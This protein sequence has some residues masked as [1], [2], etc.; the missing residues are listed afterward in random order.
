[1]GTISLSANVKLQNV[2]FVHDFKCKLIF[3]HKLTSVLSC[4][5]TYH[6]N[7]CVMQDQITMRMTESSDLWDGVYVFKMAMEGSSLATIRRYLVVI[8]VTSPNNV[9]YLLIKVIV[10]MKNFCLI[11]YYLWEKYHTASHNQS[12]FFLTI[13]DDFT[14]AT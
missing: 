11:H 7:S 10:K 13:V 14:R 4:M 5:V 1:M 3:I 2:L 8:F 12:Y 6:E 9:V